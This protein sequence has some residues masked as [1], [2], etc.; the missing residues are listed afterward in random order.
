MDRTDELTVEVSEQTKLRMALSI[1]RDVSIYLFALDTS[2]QPRRAK[3]AILT[4][5][6]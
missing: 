1:A 3:F 6:V 5:A 4:Y 2:F